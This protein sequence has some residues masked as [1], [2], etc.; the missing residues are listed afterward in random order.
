M[1]LPWET[2]E[3]EIKQQNKSLPWETEEYTPPNYTVGKEATIKSRIQEIKPTYSPNQ[4]TNYD[5]LIAETTHMLSTTPT[6]KDKVGRGE[7][8]TLGVGSGLLA[9]TGAD[10]M[11]ERYPD[12]KGWIT[13]GE[14]VGSLVP[15]GAAYKIAK[16]LTKGIANPIKRAAATGLVGDTPL[17][18]LKGG[19]EATRRGENTQGIAKSATLEGALY[20]GAAAVLGPAAE[21]GLPKLARGL[22]SSAN[23]IDN[24]LASR[25]LSIPEESVDM[26]KTVE[27]RTTPKPNL[28]PP[29][30]TKPDLTPPRVASLDM[31]QPKTV[32]SITSGEIKSPLEAVGNADTFRGKINRDIKPQKKSF[33]ETFEKIRTQFIDDLAPLEGLEKRVRGN[34]AS[35]EDSL[36]KQARLFRG[37]PE[38]AYNTINTQLK[39]IISDIEK[40]GFSYQDLGDYALAVHARDVNARGINSGFTDQ[41]ISAVLQK[42]ANT[43]LEEARKQL[44]QVSDSMLRELV[45]SEVISKEMYST[46]KE[47]WPNYMPLFR[48]FD[49]NKIDFARGLNKALTNVTSPIKRLEGSNR[50]VIDPIESMV[51]NI[52]NITNTAQRN[53]VSLQLAK[54]ADENT[55]LIRKLGP[56]EQVGRKNVVS[57]LQNGDKVKYEVEPEVYKALLNLDKE[58]SNLLMKMLSK[59]ASLL[60]AGATLTPEFSL[61]NPLRDVPFAFTVS[62]SKLNP[63]DIG[64][65]LMDTIKGKVG[66]STKLY[67]Q[68]LQD[69]GGYGNIISMDRNMHRKALEEALTK[70]VSKKFVS[71]VNPQTYLKLLRGIADTSESATKLGEYRAALR[72]GV[73]RPEAAYRSRDIMD[74]A[75]AGYSTREANKIIAFLNANVQGKS[76]MWRSFQENP[77]GVVARGTATVTLPTIAFYAANHKLANEKQK[78][79]IKDA[80]AWLKNT[81][82]LVAIPGT[83]QVG[84]IP[85]PFDL[86]PMFANFYERLM[87]KMVD[88]DPKAFDNFIKE[89]LDEQTMSV[90]PTALL[91]IIEGM[92]NKSFFRDAPIIPQREN[93]LRYPDQYD[94]NTSETAKVL[95][96]GVDKLTGGEGPFK[97]FGSPRIIDNTIRGYTAGLGSMS[98][99][100]LDIVFEGLTGVEKPDRPSKSFSQLP[101]AKAF[102]ANP[103]STGKSVDYVYTELDKLTRTRGSAKE[104]KSGFTPQEENKYQFLN[105]RAKQISEVS[106]EIRQVTNSPK[107]SGD[108][109]RERLEKLN[110]LRNKIARDTRNK[111][112]KGN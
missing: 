70:P 91:P 43:P 22:K 15:F 79:T 76:K 109:K 50:D 45:D 21:I 65:G 38:K 12:T 18:A 105:D 9:G 71:I 67:N 86:A 80:P 27:P 85:K 49:D 39:P 19:A 58:G 77:T 63:L 55:E 32:N 75:R 54:L 23:I 35:A 72:Q 13:A 83:D 28:T 110:D 107:L 3:F 108:D 2:D 11:R 14:M 101:V 59:P 51:K 26:L 6:I 25:A 42:Y 57:V 95:A 89:S 60:R 98:L 37:V 4:Y 5:P 94:I 64:F 61:R 87:D 8:F 48:S 73:S 81:F 90:I 16:P 66:M 52:F 17:G 34:I 84:R 106:K 92:S 1:K 20:G 47:K 88:N 78:E 82:W 33:A 44:N 24:K 100:A 68:W 93:N 102:F 104:G 99:D 97:T 30:Q 29:I 40:Q 111:L 56:N 103:S 31:P 41:E 62:K 112:E 74:F 36:Y 46:L 69:M 96:K 53:R 7:A 10:E